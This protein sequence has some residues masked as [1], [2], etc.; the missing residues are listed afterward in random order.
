MPMAQQKGLLDKIGKPTAVIGGII[1]ALVGIFTLVNTLADKKVELVET[2]VD[3]CESE[4]AVLE[5]RLEYAERFL[6]LP[7]VREGVKATYE[8][9]EKAILTH[10]KSGLAAYFSES[11]PERDNTLAEWEKYLGRRIFFEIQTL[12]KGSEEGQIIAAVKGEILDG[13]G[14]STWYFQDTLARESGQWKFIK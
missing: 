14:Q 5:K 13:E 7:E 6:L 11:L 8:G 9:L 1:A 4:K 12:A 10:N 3:L 2:K